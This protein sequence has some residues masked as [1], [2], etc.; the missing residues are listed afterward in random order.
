MA[1]QVDALRAHVDVDVLCCSPG[2]SDPPCRRDSGVRVTYANTATLLGSGRIGL[3][4]TTF[5]YAAA[6]RRYLKER[7]GSYDLVHA[8]FGFPDAYVAARAVRRAR[9][10][11][12]VTLH[13]D[14]AFYVAPRDDLVG[15]VMRRGLRSARIIICVSHAM[16]D[17]VW[18]VLPS[19]DVRVVSNGYDSALFRVSNGVSNAER[20]LGILF[21][22][23]LVPVKNVDLLLRAY[24]RVREHI[25]APLTIVGDGPL[26][27][28][29]EQ[30][31][32]T[33]GVADTVDFLGYRPRAEVA[34]LMQRASVLALPSSSEG[35]GLVLAEALACGTPV[36]ASRV[37]GVPEIVASSSAGTLVPPGDID[38]LT[39][40]L[41]HWARASVDRSV[42]VASSGAHPWSEAVLDVARAYR[43]CLGLP[44]E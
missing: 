20:D 27:A 18:S 6:L 17:V 15:R 16:A 22:G 13:G 44:S 37:G 8:H 12:V 29:L 23:L 14:D 38:A 40:A 1:E 34:T 42:V 11:L 2:A 33:L 43:D 30:L 41:T 35:Y 9:I 10:P 5:R 32:V 7:V 3:V 39:D 26:R 4:A 28:E 36:V 25:D 24:E 31:A 21:V 19:I